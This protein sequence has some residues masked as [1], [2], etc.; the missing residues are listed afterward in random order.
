[1][2]KLDPK[3]WQGA[4][5]WQYEAYPIFTSVYVNA[6]QTKEKNK[7]YTD[8]ADFLNKFEDGH[9]MAL[10]PNK[11]I[12]KIGNVAIKESLVGN[13]GYY[14]EIKKVHKEINIAI[15]KCLKARTGENSSLSSWWPQ[16]QKAL[17]HAANI[18]FSF[19][20]TFDG[21]L[22][23]FQEKN[24]KDFEILNSH[25]R[26]KKLSF[27][28]EAGKKLLEL[29]AKYGKNSDKVF[30]DFIKDFGW[31]QNTYKGTFKIDRKWMQ[32]HLKEIKNKKNQH[33]STEE[34]KEALPK[35]YKIISEL[36]NDVIIF[37]DDKKKLLLLAVDLIDGW[38]RR[39]SKENS[40]QF[41]VMRWLTVDEI[42]EIIETGKDK[43]LKKAEKYNNEN[44]RLGLMT[45]V[46]YL[47]IDENF[48][49]N[50]MS[51]YTSE[52]NIKEVK[53]IV[54]SRGTYRG[55]VRIIFDA[56]KDAGKFNNGDI[57]VT[58]M[59]RPEFLPLM[60]KAGAFITDEGGI[61]C[62]A[63]IVAREMKKPCIIATKNA[64]RILKDGDI[65][66][67]NANEG[68]IKIIK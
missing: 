51:F 68:I 44:K 45:H 54:A 61:S 26:N 55:V 53:G 12:L 56:K 1:M 2:T 10:K 11:Q 7:Y 65:V 36:A 37:R 43:N 50:V 46:G 18:L 13:Q 66:E 40:W 9:L 64:T 25:I 20:Y 47:D 62:H 35:K 22:K 63:A 16:T 31:F 19:D 49:D 3:N 48:W 5:K 28:D 29:D 8:W 42:I 39:K 21:F 67:V 4:F 15:E 32:H 60:S 33:L 57:L 24:P 14:K 34:K 59:T 17:S 38:I 41:E 52:D 58:S 23:E 6:S 30:N 27:M